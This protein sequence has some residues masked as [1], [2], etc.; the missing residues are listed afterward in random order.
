MKKVITLIFALQLFAVSGFAGGDPLG[1]L[2][3]SIT[4]ETLTIWGT[5]AMPSYNG[6]GSY[7]W[8]TYQNSITNIVI[9]EGVTSIGNDAFAYF[10]KLVSVSLPNSLT[11]IESWAFDDCTGLASIS[12]PNSVT[13]IGMNAFEGTALYDNQPD[14][15]VYI[16]KVLYKY[17][18]TMPENTTIQID[19]GINSIAEFAFADRTELS[20]I[21]IP[22]SVSNIGHGAFTGTKWYE[23]QPDGLIYVNKVLY[24]YKGIMPKNTTINIKAGTESISG[25]AFEGKTDL[26]ATSGYGPLSDCTGLVSVIIPNSVT[27]IGNAAFYDC[28]G[29]RS[30]V[31]EWDNP[32]SVKYGQSIISG[33]DVSTILLYVPA[34]TETAYQNHNI[35]KNFTIVNPAEDNWLVGLRVSAGKL[36][37]DFSPRLTSYRIDV[38]VSIESITLTATPSTSA[39]TVSGDGTKSLNVGENIFEIVV[40]AENGITKKTYTVTVLRSNT[41]FILEFDH[42]TESNTSG[43]ISVPYQNQVLQIPVTVISGRTNF[44]RLTTGNSSGSTSFH[45]QWGSRANNQTVDLLPNSSYIISLNIS[46]TAEATFT[47]RYDA[48]GR[49]SSTSVNYTY[50]PCELSIADDNGV[51]LT[52][53]TSLPIRTWA[54]SSLSSAI[55]FERSFS[56]IKTIETPKIAVYPNPAADFVTISGLQVNETIH[57]FDLN[58]RLWI[59]QKT[60]SES[61]TISVGQLPA[62]IY[63][64]RMGNGETVK[65]VKK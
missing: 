49:P 40:T 59:T 48:Y 50:S 13:N 29:L 42:F 31:A 11:S 23:N 1:D 30:V 7:P 46:F 55:T 33:V 21:T 19:E 25:H 61:E 60:T 47:T 65:W 15:L 28:G 22:A 32:A 9:E 54:P 26:R 27:S 8:Y 53:E 3:W 57:L 6:N 35:W 20:A 51:L 64:I 5:G 16:G 41:D 38:P 44:Y 2:S 10:R 24:Q 17:K 37:P 52:E 4:D 45:F 63:V 12:L 36:S 14:G 43:N 56:P 34:G 18:G 62:G 58:G 39:A